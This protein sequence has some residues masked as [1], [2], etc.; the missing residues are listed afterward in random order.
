VASG[1]PGAIIAKIN[2]GATAKARQNPLAVCAANKKS[3]K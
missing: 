1:S 2:K 3:D